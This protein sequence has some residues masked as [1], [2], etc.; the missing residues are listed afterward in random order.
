[1]I[2][3]WTQDLNAPSY[4]DALKIRQ[5]VF[6]EEQG[7]D[8]EL[9]IDDLEEGASHLVAYQDGLPLA[10]ARLLPLSQEEVKIQRV[11]VLSE[12]R[13]RGIGRAL[14]AEC[15]RYSQEM[16][17]KHLILHAQAGRER[18]YQLCGYQAEGDYFEEAGIPHLQMRL[19]LD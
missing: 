14:M 12:K 1:M 5:Q 15:R 13:E 2:F 3:K 16:G 6:I 8:P 9:E 18:F 17:F 4:Q 11:A 7:I 10:C 19:N